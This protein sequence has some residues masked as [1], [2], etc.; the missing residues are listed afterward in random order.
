MTMTKAEHLAWAKMRALDRL[1]HSQISL[2]WA[3][4]QSDLGKHPDWKISRQQS[5][6]G[7]EI[8]MQQSDLAMKNFIN[9][10]E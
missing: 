1:E 3:S 6:L 7:T 10:F 5:K 4:F 9:S 8:V 2:A